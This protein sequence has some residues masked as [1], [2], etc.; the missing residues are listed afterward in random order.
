MEIGNRKLELQRKWEMV[1]NSRKVLKD[2]ES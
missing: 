2:L 1:R